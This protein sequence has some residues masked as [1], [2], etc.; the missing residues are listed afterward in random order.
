MAISEQ[1][2]D[3]MLAKMPSKVQKNRKKHILINDMNQERQIIEANTRTIPGIIT[4]RGCAYAGCKGVV[5]GPIKDMVHIV[6][7]PIGCGYYA[8]GTRRNKA[9]VDDPSQNFM[10][11]CVSTDMQESDI[12]FGGEKK[13]AKVIDE[14]VDI[15]HPK[16]ITVS[17]TCPVGL[18][19]DD[20]NAVAKAAEERHG[21][22]VLSFSCEGYKG[23]SQ[24]AGHHIANNGLVDRIIGAG[25]W[26][27]APGQFPINILG[28]YNIGGDGWE[29][30]RVLKD[31]GYTVVSI[32]TGDG[33]Y[34][35][36][37]N[38]HVAELNLVQCHR[39]INYI[40]GMLETKYGTPW[41]KVNFVGIAATVESLRNMALYFDD[42]ALTQR[43]EEVIARE[44]AVIGPAIEQYRKLCEGKTAFCFVGGSRGHH[45]QGLFAELGIETVLAG[46]E[47]AHRDDY[48]GREVIPDIKT[49]ADSKNIPDLHVEADQERFRLKIPAE[50]MEELKHRIPLS[51]YAGLRAE[52]KDG[53]VIVDDL[54]HYETEEFIK[55]LKPDIFASGIK[56]K[57][58]VQKMGIPAKQLHS[59]DY[60]GPYAGFN[61]AVNFARDVSMGF[62]SPTW[63]F[64]V[65]PWRDE[66]LLIGSVATEGVA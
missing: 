41:L 37:K 27:E 66:P 50:K 3:E 38:A 16:A 11:Y 45:Y 17:A 10:N 5:L 20:M 14:V 35:D 51:Y 31:I 65:P 26:E 56:D 47:F 13:L 15:F 58:V 40:A 54:N 60:S 63:N 52:M 61:G 28:E 32:M 1:Q 22:P 55:L 30:E 62:V 42:A 57:Y 23:V 9:R 53:G 8:W 19:G 44:L 46:Y 21:I 34:E 7:G 29:I 48:E 6:H 18:I 2:L 12:V 33:S 24:S 43:T 64:I 25:D 39:S 49:D 36:L 4:N 59:Y